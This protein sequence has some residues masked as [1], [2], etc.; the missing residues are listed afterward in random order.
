MS[1]VAASYGMKRVGSQVRERLASAIAHAVRDGL[2]GRRGAFLWP[3]GLTT[4]VMRAADAAGVVRPI[5]EVAPEEIA[6]GVTAYLTHAFA[7]SRADL[8]TGV[9]REF[10]YDRTGAHVAAA[11][12]AALDQL[13]A[14]GTVRDV[15]GQ[16]RRVD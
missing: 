10:G 8:V 3:P 14:G 5:G 2:V 12:E 16:V 4:P 6:A 1:V 13:L 9:A 7:L 15:G 11:I